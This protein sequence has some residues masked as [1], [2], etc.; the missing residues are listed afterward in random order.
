MN[1]PF[2]SIIMATYN[3]GYYISRAIDSVLAQSFKEWELIIVDDGSSDNTEEIVKRY[4]DKRI[5]YIKLS[6]NSGVNVARNRG[7]KEAKG[8]WCFILDSDNMLNE[9]ILDKFIFYIQKYNFPYMKFLSK[10]LNNKVLGD[11]FSGF[12]SFE[13]FLVEKVY[14]EFHTLIKTSLQKKYPFF[15]DINGGEGIVWKLIAKEVEE[16]LFIDEVSIL[17]DDS[18]DDRLS[19]KNYKRLCP[20]FKKD[21]KILG[22]EYF[23]VDK[24]Y[25]FKAY[26]KKVYYCIRK[27]LS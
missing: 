27:S 12:V 17:Y 2:F 26:L 15:E 14:G 16:V 18:G 4:N 10:S 20:I 19:I 7:Y 23:K 11:R 24:I 3:R 21:I 5:K 25:F 9:G 6:K 8:K 22:D 1:N 13:D